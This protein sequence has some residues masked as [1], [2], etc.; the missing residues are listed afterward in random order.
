MTIACVENSSTTVLH[1]PVGVFHREDVLE[2]FA[3]DAEYLGKSNKM[4]ISYSRGCHTLC[5]LDNCYIFDI[6]E[7]NEREIPPMTLQRLNHIATI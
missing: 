6:G 1:T 7:N 5:K 4:S 2:G 3:V